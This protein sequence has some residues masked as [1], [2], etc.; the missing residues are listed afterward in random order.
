[1]EPRIKPAGDRAT[2]ARSWHGRSGFVVRKEI[3]D[4]GTE[5][6]DR[7]QFQARQQIV[8]LYTTPDLLG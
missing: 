5:R 3:K 1:M 7:R 4:H 6:K 8:A 2:C